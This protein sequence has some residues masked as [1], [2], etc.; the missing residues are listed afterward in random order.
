MKNF[1]F[2]VLMAISWPAGQ[3]QGLLDSTA[4]IPHWSTGNGLTSTLEVRSITPVVG[5]IKITFFR[6][7]GVSVKSETLPVG[8]YDT[9]RINAPASGGFIKGWAL[10]ESDVR[11]AAQLVFKTE[12]T[13]IRQDEIVYSENPKSGFAVSVEINSTEPTLVNSGVAVANP[14]DAALKIFFILKD[15]TVRDSAGV[16]AE[17]GRTETVLGVHQQIAKFVDELFPFLISRNT[18]WGTLE[19]VPTDA[20]GN[21]LNLNTRVVGM[22][23]RFLRRDDGT[24]WYNFSASPVRQLS[25]R[26]PEGLTGQPVVAVYFVA[27]DLVALNH[28]DADPE[29]QKHM[30]MLL[31]M[32]QRFFTI[33]A[34]RAGLDSDKFQFLQGNPPEVRLVV[35]NFDSVFYMEDLSRSIQ[36]V[37]EEIKEKIG[38]RR[39][40]VYSTLPVIFDNILLPAVD[41]R[42]RQVVNPAYIY[43]PSTFFLKYPVEKIKD[44]NNQD[45]NQVGQTAW[46]LSVAIKAI[47]RGFALSYSEELAKNYCGVFSDAMFN[48]GEAPSDCIAY[49]VSVVSTIFPDLVVV[50]TL[51]KRLFGRSSQ[52]WINT[53]FSAEDFKSLSNP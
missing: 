49:S 35:G 37:H 20:S 16:P 31:D 39:E 36:V 40:Y 48:G 18:F 2:A 28:P 12:I 53:I 4:Y 41:A 47:G 27:K 13:G 26:D 32:S 23:V 29:Y 25:Y 8:K 24:G 14:T 11:I 43:I 15:E 42:R 22:A 45:L 6:D 1:I 19:V 17:V 44:W 50:D 46:I 34:E 51:Q 38:P 5:T 3:G 52:F 10:V 7:D 9:V 21:L 30:S 33:E